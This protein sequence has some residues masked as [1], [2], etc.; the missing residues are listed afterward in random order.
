MRFEYYPD[1]LG[2]WRWTLRA[3]N[4]QKIA[5][6]EGHKNL[7]DCLQ[8][9]EQVKAAHSAIVEA[10]RPALGKL[11][12]PPPKPPQLDNALTRFLNKNPLPPRSPLAK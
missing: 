10:R 8:C 2:E 6:G 1:I 11:P 4:G 7:D 12:K 3:S 9:I 5:S